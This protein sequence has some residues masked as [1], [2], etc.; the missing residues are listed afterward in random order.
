MLGPLGHFLINL[1]NTQGFPPRWH[2]SKAWDAFSGWLF[3]I[4]DIAIW[5]AYFA[6]PLVLFAFVRRKKNVP[7][8]KVLALFAVFIFACGLTHLMDAAIFWWPAYH[9][10]ALLQLVTAVVSWLTVFALIPVINK[11]MQLKTPAEHEALVKA[12]TAE[13]EQ[14]K[15]RAE[16]NE[17]R[18]KRMMD[19]NIIG[20]FF[21]DLNSQVVESNMAFL[22]MIGYTQEDLAFKGLNAR[23]ITP[24]EYVPQDQ[25]VM[26]KLKETGVSGLF[27]KQYFHKLG[28]RVDVLLSVALVGSQGDTHCIVLVL[29][30]T[31]QKNDQR[32]LKEREVNI[33]QLNAELEQ[34]VLERTAQLEDANTQ[35]Q[36]AYKELESFSYS[37]SHDLRAPLRSLD[38][39]SSILLQEYSDKL[40]DYGKDYL[41]RLRSNSQK[42]GDLINHLLRLSQVSRADIHKQLVNLSDVCDDLIVDYRACMPLEQVTLTIQPNIMAQADPVLIRAVLDNLLR[43]ALKFSAGKPQPAI[44]FGMTLMGDQTT[45]FVQDNG[46]GFDMAHAGQLFR[47]FQR[48][49]RQD[50]FD[51]TGIGL[52]T[53][54]RIISRHGGNIWAEAEP[55]KG[56]TFFFTLP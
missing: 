52:A 50:E 45:Y 19:A 46:V 43:N 3:I 42:M 29:D 27:E 25:A 53:V 14:E 47:V 1:F 16:Q 30:I 12:R 10:K 39:F 26:V 55:E 20:L 24:P 37:I 48:L 18:F 54:Q 32:A 56:A 35:M 8:P 36:L 4:T 40:D 7:F 15:Q 22:G 17:A 34:K 51:G 41:N 33:K 21:S 44:T 49:H 13:L 31:Q 28:H 38:G 5:G 2:C 11:A 9:F 6:I 23:A